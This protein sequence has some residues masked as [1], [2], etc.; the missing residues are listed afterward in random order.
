MNSCYIP[1]R[2]HL[3]TSPDADGLKPERKAQ[4]VTHETGSFCGLIRVK[5]P[6]R[7]SISDD[8]FH[9]RGS[10][11]PSL[12]SRLHGDAASFSQSG[13]RVLFTR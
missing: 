10:S 11:L 5:W 12:S 4:T 2:V 7:L 9:H 3:L 13:G 8:P 6:E 1:V